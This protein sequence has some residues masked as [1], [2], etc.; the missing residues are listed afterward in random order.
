MRRT[1]LLL[2][3]M[4]LA[5]VLVGGVATSKQSQDKQ[6]QQQEEGTTLSPAMTT[7]S[8]ASND[9]DASIQGTTTP[10]IGHQD[11]GGAGQKS[12]AATASDSK[13]VSKKGDD[14]G[15]GP[16]ESIAVKASFANGTGASF[17]GVKVSDH[18][19]LVS[20][21]SPAGQE[22]L[23][24]GEGYAVCSGGGTTIHGHDTN[25]ANDEGATA[26]FGTPTFAQPNG[27]GT[28]PLT[29]TR[30]TT[31][32]KFQLSQVWAK[33]DATEKDVT[34]TMTIKNI[35][36]TGS[37]P[38]ATINAVELAR[39][40]DFDV[41][42]SIQDWG[43]RTGDAVWL[44]DDASGTDVPAVGLQLTAL[45]LGIAHDPW[46]EHY[47]NWIDSTTGTRNGCVPNPVAQTPTRSDF[48]MRAVYHLG[49]MS[50]GQSKTVKYEYE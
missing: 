11:Q 42:T 6:D 35:T 39:T 40:G 3:T 17:L 45:T 48:T 44:W 22:A 27:A 5:L 25:G 19:N 50:A 33:P 29:V 26:T 16:I 47:N 7:L 4:A 15:S 46:V 2:A 41:G 32:G 14:K 31:N 23:G 21:E 13:A 43:A 24:N 34:V 8:P 20:F 37:V 9:G 38:A 12:A 18:G 28:F 30:R 10:A 36:G 1:L 49:N